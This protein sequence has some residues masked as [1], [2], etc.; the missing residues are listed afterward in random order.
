MQ[1]LEDI[2]RNILTASALL[3]ALTFAPALALADT[4]IVITPDVD[5]WV[6]EQPDT[7][8]TFDGDIVVGAELPGTVK[9]I[10]HPKHKDYG[11]VVVN[12]KRVLVD[13]NNRRVIKIYQ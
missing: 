2:M 6:M 5:T 10:D 13:R 8:V 11:Y 1:F 7:S 9:F 4:K 3:T 12:K